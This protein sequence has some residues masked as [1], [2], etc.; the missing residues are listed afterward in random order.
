MFLNKKTILVTFI[1]STVTAMI[2]LYISLAM[3]GVVM[4]NFE[5]GTSFT[6]SDKIIYYTGMIISGYL[7]LPVFILPKYIQ[8]SFLGGFLSYV[9]PILMVWILILPLYIYAKK[10]LTHKNK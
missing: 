2:L 1:I 9:F 6:L 4:N 5:T 10:Q 7:M 8:D 3:T